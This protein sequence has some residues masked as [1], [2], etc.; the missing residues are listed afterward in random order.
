MHISQQNRWHLKVESQV[1]RFKHSNYLVSN[2]KYSLKRYT[3]RDIIHSFS[4][5]KRPQH[6]P[7]LCHHSWK[8]LH[9]WWNKLWF[10]K[11]RRKEASSK[12]STFTEQQILFAYS[13]HNLDCKR[14]TSQ[15]MIRNRATYNTIHVSLEVTA[16][17]KQRFTSTFNL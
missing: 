11:R 9:I 13:Q 16:P 8:S 10:Y 1:R 17:F 4:K 3:S 15:E 12:T 6:M 14:V 2:T 5:F 7:H